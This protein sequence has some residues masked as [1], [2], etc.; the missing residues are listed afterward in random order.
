VPILPNLCGIW[1]SQ[2]KVGFVVFSKVKE[3]VTKTGSARKRKWLK[4]NHPQREDQ[5]EIK[6]KLSGK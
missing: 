5:V 3:G 6:I 2:E 4:T 1:Q